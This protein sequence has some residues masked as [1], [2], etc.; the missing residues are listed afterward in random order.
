MD[1]L[2]KKK[3]MTA[4][5]V[6]KI[7][8]LM[9]KETGQAVPEPISSAHMIQ[10]GRPKSSGGGSMRSVNSGGSGSVRK[11][12]GEGALGEVGKD[13]FNRVTSGLG[14]V[15]EIRESTWENAYAGG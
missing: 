5:D 13:L 7:R 1:T 10:A 12:D 4:D 11:V 3:T 9:C 15:D 6:K 2:M 8:M 14:T